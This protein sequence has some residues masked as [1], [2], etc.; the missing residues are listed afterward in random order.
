MANFNSVKALL[1]SAV[2]FSPLSMAQEDIETKV[3]HKATE[4]EQ[5]HMTVSPKS[6]A[7]ASGPGKDLT[8]STMPSGNRTSHSFPEAPAPNERNTTVEMIKEKK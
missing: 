4:S 3:V 8:N 6:G 5:V 1:V 7:A 2:I